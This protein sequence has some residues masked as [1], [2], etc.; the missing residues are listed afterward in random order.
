MSDNGHGITTEVVTITPTMAKKWLA[1]TNYE[2]N[3]NISRGRVDYY[4]RQIRDGRWALNGETI[5]F[6]TE[7][8]LLN[9]QHRLEAIIKAKKSA[10]VLVVRGVKE[11]AFS[12]MDQGYNRNAGQVMGMKGLKN[13]SLRAAICRALFIWEVSGGRLKNY[14]KISPDELMMVQDI[15]AEE[16]DAATSYSNR[17]RGEVPM[18]SGVIGLGHILFTRARS[19]K[20]EEFLRVFEDGLTAIAGHPALVLRRRLMKDK[21]KDRQLPFDA[22]WAAMIRAW[23]AYDKGE[24]I[25]T[26][27]VK[28]NPDGEWVQQAIRGLGAKA[29]QTKLKGVS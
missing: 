5:I 16:I 7:G 4:A 20:C 23:N 12:T 28:R 26:I 6:D 3:R 14:G 11:S 25:R 22:Q 27:I 18:S 29:K 2:E 24:T 9:G 21:M 17:C 8:G 15:Y 13:A 10:V 1:E 19:T